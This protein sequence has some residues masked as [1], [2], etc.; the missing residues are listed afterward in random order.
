MKGEVL[1][2]YEVL[3]KLGEG[4]M[5]V[6]YRARDTLLGREVAVK[7]LSPAALARSDRRKRLLQEARAASRLNHPNIVTIYEVGVQDEQVFIAMEL[8]RGRTLDQLIGRP[9]DPRQVVK[10]AIQIADGLDCAQ[11]AGIVHRDLK[12]SNIFL[13]DSGLVKIVDFGLAKQVHPEGEPGSGALTTEGMVIGTPSYMSPEQAE[14]RPV[15]TRSDLFALGILLYEMLSGQ[16][17]FARDTSLASV[18]AILNE[19]PPPA[20]LPAGFDFLIRCCLDKNPDRRYQRAADLRGAL[21]DLRFAM[22]NQPS[23]LMARV[24]PGRRPAHTIAVLPFTDMSPGRDQEWFCDGIAEEIINALTTIDHLKVASRTSAFRFKGQAADISE[25]G[26]QLRVDNV[27]EGSVRTHADR[28]R[29]T[30]QLIDVR[31]G[32]HLWSARYDRQLAD[33]FAIQEE[34]AQAIVDTFRLHLDRAQAARMLLRHSTD[35]GAYQ[36]Y[37]QGRYHWN[38]RTMPSVRQAI[39]YF[40]KAI[41][42]DPEYVLA[43]AG[44]A[45]CFSTCNYYGAEPPASLR[46]R[47]LEAARRALALGPA[48]AEPHTAMGLVKANFEYDIHGAEEHFRRA[49]EINPN[50]STARYFYAFS[51]LAPQGRLAEAI[52][53]TQRA[54]A[55]EPLSLPI[56]TWKGAI[57]YLN[58]EYELSVEEYLRVVELDPTFVRARLEI[59]LPL[60]A[61]GRI[62][63]G[64]Q[65]LDEAR[66]LAGDTPR[67]VSLR[68]YG[69]G[70][71]GR[72]REAEEALMELELLGESMFV[73]GYERALIY[74]GLGERVSALEALRQALVERSPWLIF[75]QQSPIFDDLRGEAGF[76]PIVRGVKH[77][78]RGSG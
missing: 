49:L 67:G 40:E 3:D 77:A 28:L 53:E 13:L 70:R 60:F 36:L 33:I 5:G 47:A 31:D 69:C 76:A 41:Q 10:I 55:L 27:L 73:G 66:E 68:G 59:A 65:H 14:G 38:K 61:L 52:M 54:L 12:P 32:Y 24:E 34:I 35:A 2:H 42:R 45:D 78:A 64:L 6:V 46:E 11:Q 50:S 51:S 75:I 26:R 8:L 1:S 23:R 25:I 18:I 62:P 17:A 63:E 56:L 15:D 39:S 30:A 58:R 57:H 21:E 43:Y 29:I 22:Q 74:C 44:L 9:L 4:G 72:R 71:S 20:E 48:L 37:L 7:V 19:E 16:R